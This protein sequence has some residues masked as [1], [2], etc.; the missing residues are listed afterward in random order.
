MSD[1]CDIRITFDR[2][3]RRYRGGETVRGQVHIKVNKDLRCNGI[4]LTHYWKTHGRGNS[5]SGQKHTIQLSEMVPLQSGE[6]LH[7]PF[8]FVAER[9]PVTYHGHLIYVDH[10]VLVEVDLPWAFDPKSE[11]EYILLPGE[12]PL[13]MTGSRGEIISFSK[14]STP[15]NGVLKMFLMGLLI[16]VTLVLGA[17]ALFL[18]PLIVI[19]IIFYFVRKQMIAARVGEV[20]FKLP[21]VVVGPGESWP[22]ELSFTPKKSF[23][24]N[25]ITVKLMAQELATSGSGTN[26][27]TSRHVLHEQTVTL[28]PSDHLM[29]GERFS[30]RV[31]IDFPAL[32]YWSLK[33][34][35]NEVKWT[36]EVR[37]DIPLCPDWSTTTELQ[38]VP[39]E[40][41]DDS[42]PSSGQPSPARSIESHQTSELPYNAAESVPTSMGEESDSFETAP[43]YSDKPQ[44]NRAGSYGEDMAPLLQLIQRIADAGRFG[45]ERSEITAAAEGHVYE[46]EV[47]VDRISTTFTFPGSDARY[48]KG[49]T[50][51]G[52]LVGADQE[53]QI[54]TLD[55]DNTT[56]GDVSRGELLQIPAIV[57]GWDSLYNRLVMHEWPGD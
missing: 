53:V 33:E 18:L 24:L 14:P 22:V 15:V 48:K 43:A 2:P 41:L 12:R 4:V 32:E 44:Q 6:E 35:D 17:L 8:E 57:A 30:K 40:F 38:V 46:A 13:E 25:G 3:D 56:S 34:S 26:K 42:H 7:F 47:I 50:I 21:H 5:D 45:N 20:E 39:V 27:T 11:E 52:K 54:Y 1:K 19:G 16:L 28:Q 29:A 49:K 36:A 55:D 23:N 10:Y 31:D 51:I 37:I 9:R